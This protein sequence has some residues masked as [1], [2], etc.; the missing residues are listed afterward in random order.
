MR[1][2]VSYGQYSDPID[3]PS[4]RVSRPSNGIELRLTASSRRNTF[5]PI[6]VTIFDSQNHSNHCNSYANVLGFIAE[7]FSM[8]LE[9]LSS[10]QRWP[11]LGT[12][13]LMSCHLNIF[14]LVY[15]SR[16]TS[17]RW[18]A[19]FGTCHPVRN[20]ISIQWASSFLYHFW[21]FNRITKPLWMNSLI[22]RHVSGWI[23]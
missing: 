14:C 22:S 12:V 16:E 10:L 2:F 7:F 6:F 11:V 23:Y 20:I 1:I 9:N 17:E 4:V 18:N 15:I 3:R 19:Y 8:I 13:S 5:L 21:H